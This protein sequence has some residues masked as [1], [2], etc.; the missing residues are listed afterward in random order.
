MKNEIHEGGGRCI[1]Q[2]KQH[3]QEFIKVMPSFHDHLFHICIHNVHLI[4]TQFQIH[5]TK[6]KSLISTIKKIINSRQMVIIFNGH[7]FVQGMVANAHAQ[8]FV[9]YPQT[10]RGSIRQLT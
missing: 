2:P 1:T 10:H 3:D 6:I 5:S 4:I 7:D 9:F 8:H